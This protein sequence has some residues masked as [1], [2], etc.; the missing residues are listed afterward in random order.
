MRTSCK[1]CGAPLNS[2]KCDYCGIV[3]SDWK[4]DPQQ[5]TDN[6][7]YDAPYDN[8][9][10]QNNMSDFDVPQ[11]AKH[12]LGINTASGVFA[13]INAIVLFFYTRFLWSETALTSTNTNYSMLG[14]TFIIIIILMITALILHII[15]LAQSKKMGISVAGHILGIIA[16][17]IT[18]LTLT[19]FSFISII[20]FI[21]AAIFTLKHKKVKPQNIANY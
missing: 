5:S 20:L 14:L 18:L 21:L 17:V 3:H 9:F 4:Q 13:I 16:A 10:P 15:G 12:K 2:R 7:N 8:N 1:S 6:L 19:F 11:T